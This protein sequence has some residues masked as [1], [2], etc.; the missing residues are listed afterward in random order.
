MANNR[1]TGEERVNVDKD[2]YFI[3]CDFAFAQALE[4][5]GYTDL[6][7]LLDTV[8]AGKVQP[9]MIKKIIECSLK[10]FNGKKIPPNELE[11]HAERI[12]TVKGFQESWG[13]CMT[14]LDYA[15][16]GAEKK[17]F[18]FLPKT[19]VFLMLKVKGLTSLDSWKQP[20]LW[21]WLFLTFGVSACTAFSVLKIAG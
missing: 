18:L 9:S 15:F 17:P 6:A 10:T 2:V 3:K 8:G 1:Y 20:F 16:Y 19:M 14:I 5:S 21:T 7:A 12:A 11:E 4:D 13:L